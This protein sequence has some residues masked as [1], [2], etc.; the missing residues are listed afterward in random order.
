ML[1]REARILQREIY[2][3]EQSHLLEIDISY[4]IPDMIRATDTLE[5]L[6]TDAVSTYLIQ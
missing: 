4:L 1:L 5:A 3:L 6:M 2:R